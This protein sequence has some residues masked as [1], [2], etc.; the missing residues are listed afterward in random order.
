MSG[1]YANKAVAGPGTFVYVAGRRLAHLAVPVPRAAGHVS[2][3]A[4]AD[5]F[6]SLDRPA[7]LKSAGYY[8]AKVTRTPFAAL[9]DAM[10]IWFRI[11]SQIQTQRAASHHSTGVEARNLL[12][13]MRPARRPAFRASPS[14]CPAWRACGGRGRRLRCVWH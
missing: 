12:C 4:P 9:T 7:S 8:A 2:A 13:S 3:M 11:L 1:V 14:A 6:R 5:P 10:T